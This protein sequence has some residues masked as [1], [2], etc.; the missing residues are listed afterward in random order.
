MRLRVAS[1]DTDGRELAQHSCARGPQKEQMSTVCRPCQACQ[2]VIVL[3]GQRPAAARRDCA[4]DQFAIA[5]LAGDPLTVARESVL[6]QGKGKRCLLTGCEIACSRVLQVSL[7]N[8]RIDGG[9]PATVHLC[10]GLAPQG[11]GCDFSRRA[12]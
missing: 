2:T 9:A 12:T 4:Q 8:R 11:P 10:C 1:L 6:V 7:V 5:G 3:L